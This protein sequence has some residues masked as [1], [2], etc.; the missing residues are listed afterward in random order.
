[1]DFRGSTD[2][3]FLGLERVAHGKAAAAEPPRLIA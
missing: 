2:M 1:L 3:E